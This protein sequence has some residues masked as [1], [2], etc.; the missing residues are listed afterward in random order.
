MRCE[1][2]QRTTLLDS[3]LHI[4]SVEAVLGASETHVV[5]AGE[6]GVLEAFL[7]RPALGAVESAMSRKDIVSS[8]EKGEVE[9]R[10]ALETPLHQVDDLIQPRLLVPRVDLLERHR[11]GAVRIRR[12][13]DHDGRIE[14][15]NELV[16]VPVSGFFVVGNVALEGA[17]YEQKKVSVRRK[18]GRRKQ[19]LTV[20]GGAALHGLLTEDGGN[21]GK[22]LSIV[23]RVEEG[24]TTGKEAKKDDAAGPDIERYGEVGLEGGIST[25]KD[26]KGEGSTHRRSDRDI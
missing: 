24:E 12:V 7:S 16:E 26:G 8:Y 6:E 19:E 10:S 14:F 13:L 9:E 17:V 11:D 25:V 18:R 23:V 1:R 5:H 3:S 22:R 4:L 15:A 2:K 20:N 21:L